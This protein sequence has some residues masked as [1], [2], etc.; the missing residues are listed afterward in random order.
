MS[1]FQLGYSHTA[2]R[3]AWPRM[4]A[5]QQPAARLR[6]NLK[7]RGLRVPMRGGIL[8]HAGGSPPGP[9]LGLGRSRA[10]KAHPSFKSLECNE[11]NASTGWFNTAKRQWSCCERRGATLCTHTGAQRPGAAEAVGYFNRASLLFMTY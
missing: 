11:Q 1:P 5:S 7:P 4:R 2:S 10:T 6:A 9:R 8:W 3:H